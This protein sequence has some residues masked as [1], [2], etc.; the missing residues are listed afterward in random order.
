MMG[1]WGYG[2]GVGGTS[3]A[4]MLLTAL[5]AALIIAGLVILIVWV[6]RAASGDHRYATHGG[7]G[8]GHMGRMEREN[9]ARYQAGGPDFIGPGPGGGA[10]GSQDNAVEIARR[11][12]AAGEITK[13]QYDEILAALNKQP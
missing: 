6:I 8:Q 12:F 1:R 13:E 11:R 5:F 3:W 4:G 7:Y 10:V 9:Q 2:Y